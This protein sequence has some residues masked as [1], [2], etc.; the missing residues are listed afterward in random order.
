MTNPGVVFPSPGEVMLEDRPIPSP[1][2]GQVLL[3]TRRSMPS[4]GTE[5]TV[6][7]G[8]FS[9]SSAWGRYGRY[10]FVAGY[11]AAAEVVGRA[12]DVDDLAI[13]DIVA[14]ATP[15]TLFV[16]V[17]AADVEPVRQRTVHLDHLP[18]VTLGQV[19]MNGVRRGRVT[20]GETVVV[21]GAGIVGQLAARF[22]RIAGARPVVVIDPLQDRLDRLPRDPAMI[23]L[24][25]GIGELRQAVAEVTG[26]RMADV[27]FEVT[28]R[29]DLIPGEF[30]A[31]SPREG[32]FVLLSSPRGTTSID[33]HDLCNAPSHTIIG[34][35][36]SSHPGRGCGENA[37]T[38]ARHARLM[39]DLLGS[40]D[41]DLE[42][43]ITSR[44]AFSDAAQ[45]YTRL[46]AAPPQ[47]LGIILDWD[48]P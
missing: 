4:P 47:D 3:R 15:H 2:P 43:L 7:S 24:R 12:P 45:A 29:P 8:A 26:G 36:N 1:G 13:G 34:A 16:V 22:C 28:G 40:G 41:L 6:L 21:F 17:D 32:R 33:F 18:F 46:S 23:A 39:L 11:S 31:L 35:H 44:L 20:W 37:W 38:S 5:V 30:E 27:V 48:C 19:A 25:A 14:S 10:P 42:P 9:E